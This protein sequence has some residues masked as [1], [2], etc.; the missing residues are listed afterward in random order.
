MYVSAEQTCYVPQLQAD[1]GVIVPLENLQGEVHPDGGSVVL[2]EDLVD[3]PLDDGGL[4]HSQL[5]DDQNFEQMLLL[6]VRSSATAVTQLTAKST[7]LKTGVV[8]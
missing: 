1:H 3:V 6:H 4:A 7:K 2:G 8:V 5:P